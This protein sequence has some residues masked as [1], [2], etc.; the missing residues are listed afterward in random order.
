M[1][2]SQSWR[3]IRKKNEMNKKKKKITCDLIHAYLFVGR[4]HPHCS[5]PD[6]VRYDHS[7]S[8]LLH[9]DLGGCQAS[10]DKR[11]PRK[12][13]STHPGIGL[14]TLLQNTFECWLLAEEA[15]SRV[16]REKYKERKKKK[17]KHAIFPSVRL[18]SLPFQRKARKTIRWG[19]GLGNFTASNFS[20]FEHSFS[21]RT[22]Y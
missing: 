6:L 18:D 13:R 5:C 8:F 17:R 20:Q 4:G 2:D 15:L 9:R 19:R 10:I 11:T 14:C 22:A 3:M 1:N 7:W 21:S 16:L 12:R